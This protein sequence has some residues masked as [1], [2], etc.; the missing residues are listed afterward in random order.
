MRWEDAVVGVKQ[1][2]VNWKQSKAVSDATG[3]EKAWS[4]ARAAAGSTP[5]LFLFQLCRPELPPGLPA[6]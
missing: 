4:W 6:G 1:S 2:N 3:R 5:W